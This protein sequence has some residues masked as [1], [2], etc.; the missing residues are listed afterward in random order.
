[1]DQRLTLA[2]VIG[3]V[4][5]SIAYLTG[6]VRREEEI[7]AA[8]EVAISIPGIRGVKQE[9]RINPNLKISSTPTEVF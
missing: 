8:E 2:H 6:E 3:D 9:I 7:T 4:W 1:M 5:D